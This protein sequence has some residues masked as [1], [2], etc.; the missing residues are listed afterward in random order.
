M[1]NNNF[2]QSLL[3]QKT[4]VPLSRFRELDMHAILST[5][6]A[7]L[8]GDGGWI[9][10]GVDNNNNVVDVPNLNAAYVSTEVTKNI[11]PMP[12]VYVQQE[13]WQERLILLITVIKGQR[14][15]YSKN[16]R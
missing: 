7:F 9:V 12:L 16:G 15:P 11:S 1:I 6:C 14:A 8:N 2:I 10:V 5:I 4:D 3:A 13:L